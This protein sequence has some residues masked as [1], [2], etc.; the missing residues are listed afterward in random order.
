[1]GAMNMG[2]ATPFM[3]AFNIARGAAANVYEVLERPSLIDPYS[4]EGIRPKDTNGFVGECLVFSLQ[5]K[6]RTR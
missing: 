5:W 3:E 4:E 2:Q 1:M 6:G